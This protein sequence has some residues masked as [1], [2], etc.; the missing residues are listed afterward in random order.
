LHKECHRKLKTILEPRTRPLIENGLGSSLGRTDSHR[1]RFGGQV[2]TPGLEHPSFI[3]PPTF[4]EAAKWKMERALAS[5]RLRLQSQR[6]CFVAMWHPEN[7]LNYLSLS[8]AIYE[9]AMLTLQSTSWTKW[10]GMSR[11]QTLPGL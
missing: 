2:S 5:G 7:Y 1:V 9:W 6:H 4:M 3:F 10:T 8:F 11:S